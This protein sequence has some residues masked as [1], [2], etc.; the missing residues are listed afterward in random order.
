LALLFAARL[1]FFMRAST[2]TTREP[3]VAPLG[4]D[5]ALRTPDL[6]FEATTYT[7]SGRFCFEA[8]AMARSTSLS[9]RPADMSGSLATASARFLA[10]LSRASARVRFLA[11]A[12]ATFLIGLAAKD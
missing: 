12:S 5:V 7:L 11:R 10:A 2:E 3:F 8:R 4:A 6:D 9:L 1:S